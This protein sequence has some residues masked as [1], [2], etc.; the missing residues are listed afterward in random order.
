[1]PAADI[2]GCLA[3]TAQANGEWSTKM[4][5]RLEMVSVKFPFVLTKPNLEM[6]FNASTSCPHADQL[7]DSYHTR[8][9][10]ITA[11]HNNTIM[12]PN[13]MPKPTPT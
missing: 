12:C 3:T 6:C 2:P 10:M 13:K 7:I 4:A 5:Q 1:M 11:R 8:H 9:L